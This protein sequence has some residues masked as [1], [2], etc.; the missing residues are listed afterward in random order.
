MDMEEA[1]ERLDIVEDLMQLVSVNRTSQQRRDRLQERT[2]E[3]PQE[4][5]QEQ[6]AEPAAEQLRSRQPQQLPSEAETLR[7]ELQLRLAFI[8]IARELPGLARLLVTSL[9]EGLR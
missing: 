8:T 6:E 3:Q 7:M 2:Q 5:P 1:S 9:L 4:Q